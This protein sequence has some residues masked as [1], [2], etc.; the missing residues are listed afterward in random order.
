MQVD[1]IASTSDA[2][3]AVMLIVNPIA[4]QVHV[5]GTLAWALLGS[6][7]MNSGHIWTR[8]YTLRDLAITLLECAFN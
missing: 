7:L 1:A 5:T 6:F 4:I 2:V 3:F 8:L